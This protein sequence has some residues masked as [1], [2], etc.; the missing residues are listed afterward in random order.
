MTE[1]HDDDEVTITY[2][3]LQRAMR[4][5]AKAER[6]RIIAVVDEEFVT[7]RYTWSDDKGF[8]EPKWQRYRGDLVWAIRAG[9]R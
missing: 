2:G 1:W 6:E 7:A 4:E 3:S 8:W 5:A 9:T